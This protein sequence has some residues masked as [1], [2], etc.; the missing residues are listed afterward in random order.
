[1]NLATL[2]HQSA[3]NHAGHIALRCGDR[4]WTYA[5]LEGLAARLAAGLYLRG[6]RPGD[7][8]AFLLPNSPELVFIHLACIQLGA[9]AVPLNPR[10]AGCEQAYILAHSGSRLCIA[11][12]ALFPALAAERPA[13][14]K[15]GDW[16]VVGSTLPVGTAAFAELLTSASAVPT[17]IEGE[18]QAPAAILYTSGTTA[19]PKGAVHSQGGLAAAV[20]NY[21]AAVHLLD[22]V[23][24]RWLAEELRCLG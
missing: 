20:Q 1:M 15:V 6:I 21:A 5:E 12:A 4:S 2:L 10:L 22:S 9:V 14:P 16:F 3:S 23:E 8:V 17:R 19:R 24:P 7:R 11:E 13:L 18:N